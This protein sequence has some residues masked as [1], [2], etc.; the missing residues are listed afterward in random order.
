MPVQMYIQ[1]AAPTLEAE[2]DMNEPKHTHER[3]PMICWYETT[4][5]KRVY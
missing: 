2:L 4:Y 3:I 5:S 1:R